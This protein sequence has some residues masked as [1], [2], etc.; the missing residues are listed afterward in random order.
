MIIK[1]KVNSKTK[2]LY[3]LL[4]FLLITIALLIDNVDVKQ[5][6]NIYYHITPQIK[7]YKYINK[8]I[9][10][11]ESNG[12]LEE[13][14]IKNCACYYFDNIIKIENFDIYNILIDVKSYKIILVY[15]ICNK[16][17]IR[18]KPLPIM[19]D[20]IDGFIRVYDG[21]RYLVLFEGEKYDFIYN[22]IS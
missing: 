20:K 12:K 19:F 5:N 2:K 6:K 22:K 10:K 16:T 14:D 15:N 13:I 3:I 7:K 11:M 18:A 1:L 9:I 4:T 21:T 8:Y 17:L